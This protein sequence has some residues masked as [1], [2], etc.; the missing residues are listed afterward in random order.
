VRIDADRWPD[1][2]TGIVSRAGVLP[3]RRNAARRPVPARI[4]VAARR[5]RRGPT[6][7]SADVPR[8]D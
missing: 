6:P 1:E 5:V 8:T 4:D 7:T 3:T 2:V